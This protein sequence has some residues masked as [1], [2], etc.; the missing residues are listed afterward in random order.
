LAT[1]SVASTIVAKRTLQDR[2]RI[3]GERDRVREDLRQASTALGQ[4][5]AA[6]ATS[7]PL[8][9]AAA[10]PT[11]KAVLEPALAYY[12]KYVKVHETDK[13]AF[14]STAGAYYQMATIYA[15]LGSKESI[16]SLGEGLQYV[17]KLCREPDVDPAIFPSVQAST[18]KLVTQGDW[19]AARGI[20][21]QEMQRLGVGLL[22][23]A[24]VASTALEGIAKKHPDA[25]NVRDDVAGLQKVV[26]T[27][28]ALVGRNEQ[29]LAAW[30]LAR[31]MLETLVRDRPDDAEFKTRLA[32]SLIAAA[33]L[34]KSAK[35][36]DTATA[37]YQRAVEVR[38]Q[39]AAANP[40]DKTR[41]QE[42]TVVKREFDKL[43]PA[44]A[45]SDAPA[46]SPPAAD[47][48]AAAH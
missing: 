15:K 3:M 31:D 6:V 2:D 21:P 44:Q 40:D 22:L 43:K 27:I 34:Q 46:A 47:A 12:Q 41:Q 1:V 14:A 16:P 38:E 45:S 42:L 29:A 7:S 4:C 36:L 24:G 30:L 19:V 25:V 13:D 48:P 23:N 11:R 20:P 33:K 37:N 8:K 10:E 28:L 17:A 18:L 26:A 39:L 32:E 9:G 5:V 35:Q